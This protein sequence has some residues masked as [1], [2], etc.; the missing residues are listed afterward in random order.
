[1]VVQKKQVAFFVDRRN[2]LAGALA[3]CGCGGS[4]RGM[5]AMKSKLRG[6]RG[7]AAIR[8]SVR[9]FE[10]ARPDPRLV[11]TRIGRLR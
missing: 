8:V 5:T 3:S 11:T 2:P 6:A 4:S 9:A 1:V 7:T 10:L